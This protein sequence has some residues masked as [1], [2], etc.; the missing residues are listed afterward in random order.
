M[1][2]ILEILKKKWHIYF[3]ERKQKYN[4][5]FNTWLNKEKIDCHWDI[6]SFNLWI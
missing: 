6:S 2:E 1:H 3:K 4:T 5:S